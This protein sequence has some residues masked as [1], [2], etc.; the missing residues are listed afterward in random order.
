MPPSASAEGETAALQARVV[1]VG[2]LGDTRVGEDAGEALGGAAQAKKGADA[3]FGNY[4]VSSTA[5]VCVL[6]ADIVIARV[7]VRDG[8]R[9]LS[10]RIVLYYI[11]GIRYSE[12]GPVC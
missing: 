3:G 1:D 12:C 11:G 2:A 8:T 6:E 9:L 4:I 10:H 5:D 7:R